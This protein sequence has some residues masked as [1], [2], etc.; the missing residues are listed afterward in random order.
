M[1]LPVTHEHS[2]DVLEGHEP[3]AERMWRGRPAALLRRHVP[4]LL[5]GGGLTVALAGGLALLAAQD[6]TSPAPQDTTRAAVVDA[7]G[8]L[9]VEWERPTPTDRPHTTATSGDAGRRSSGPIS[10]ILPD[11][12]LSGFAELQVSFAAKPA[13][14]EHLWTS[15]AWGTV[16]ATFEWTTCDG[17]IA[18]GFDR[19]PH[20]TG[21]SVRLRCDD[22]SRF[23]ASVIKQRYVDE[24]TDHGYQVWLAL[25]DGSYVAG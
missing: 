1:P 12:H 3:P 13:S 23:A 5:A 25:E 16:H 14:A 17:P 4:L 19:E 11:R 8:R 2:A 7:S 6:D 9:V 22:G 21:G 20:E 10:L 15:F 24:A 18:W